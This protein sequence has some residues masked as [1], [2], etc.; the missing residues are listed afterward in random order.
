MPTVMFRYRNGVAE[1]TLYD[2]NPYSRNVFIKTTDNFS[3]ET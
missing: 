1:F 2:N 3:I